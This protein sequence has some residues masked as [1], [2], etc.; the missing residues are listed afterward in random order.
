MPFLHQLIELYNK[1]GSAWYY[2]LEPTVS[3]VN[4]VAPLGNLGAFARTPERDAVGTRNPYTWYIYDGFEDWE[5]YTTTECPKAGDT[6]YISH[7]A[8]VGYDNGITSVIYDSENY[9]RFKLPRKRSTQIVESVRNEDGTWYRLYADGWVEQGGEHKL[10]V[11]SAYEHLF[12]LPIEMQDTNYVVM[13]DP[14]SSVDNDCGEIICE[15]K[16]TT[17][18]RV[19]IS[20]FASTSGSKGV[21]W[22]VCGQSA[23]DMTKYQANEKYLYFYVGKFLQVAVVSCR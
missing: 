22:Q 11:T 3:A 23:L 10:T 4:V 14:V 20:D 7:T 9:G 19:R 5:V 1:T 12:N 16:A 2:L 21:M 18:F 15:Y 17:A 6:F 13:Q 8:T